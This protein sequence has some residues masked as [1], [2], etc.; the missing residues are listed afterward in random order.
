V[1]LDDGVS[2]GAKAV[3]ITTSK[4]IICGAITAVAAVAED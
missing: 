2:L 1:G 3:R 4:K